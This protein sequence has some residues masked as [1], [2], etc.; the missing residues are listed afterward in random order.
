MSQ[1]ITQT[2]S[3]LWKP[4]RNG[5]IEFLSSF[6]RL[7]KEDPITAGIIE[8]KEGFECEDAN[9]AYKVGM[10][11]FGLWCSRKR[12]DGMEVIP[13]QLEQ[14]DMGRPPQRPDLMPQP[15]ASATDPVLIGM[16]GQYIDAIKAQTDAIRL[17]T[18]AMLASTDSE[19]ENIRKQVMTQ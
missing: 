19:R 13:K 18:L 5:N 17:Q 9:Y 12:L 2:P 16:M 4:G 10:S 14:N 8:E 15:T 6:K 1:I 7:H 11:R 3:A